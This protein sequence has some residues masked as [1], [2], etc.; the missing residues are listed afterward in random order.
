VRKQRRVLHALETLNVTPPEVA[1]PHQQQA[2]T[3]EILRTVL[4]TCGP[5]GV[6]VAATGLTQTTV[7]GMTNDHCNALC[8]KLASHKDW[9]LPDNPHLQSFMVQLRALSSACGMFLYLRFNDH[10]DREVQVTQE[11]GSSGY[12]R[13]VPSE[14]LHIGGHGMDQIVDGQRAHDTG[15]P[16]PPSVTST[17]HIVWVGMPTGLETIKYNP[18][19][20]V[21]VCFKDLEIFE[22]ATSPF[23]AVSKGIMDDLKA[24]LGPSFLKYDND[25]ARNVAFIH[26]SVLL[27][28][29]AAHLSGAT[30]E[31]YNWESDEEAFTRRVLGSD[32]DQVLLFIS[33]TSCD[34][35]AEALYRVAHYL[36]AVRANVRFTQRGQNGHGASKRLAMLERWTML[37]VCQIRG[38]LRRALA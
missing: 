20:H 25:K 19:L 16:S 27:I 23:Q 2:E 9:Q 26:Q 12:P 4:H 31:F 32:H 33:D 29:F 18:Y 38:G 13:W 5:Y 17:R 28:L 14:S 11:K 37:I 22:D 36:E 30:V 35:T 21:R 1:H 34:E 3:P 7:S 24:K 10:A 8:E 6:L 15:R